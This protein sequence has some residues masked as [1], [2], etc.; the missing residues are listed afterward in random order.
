MRRRQLQA[1]CKS[2][3]QTFRCCR[4]RNT[5]IRTATRR[6]LMRSR[7]RGQCKRRGSAVNSTCIYDYYMPISLSQSINQLTRECEQSDRQYTHA[8]ISFG[9][10]VT[11]TFD[12]LNS[13]SMPT[14][15][16]PGTLSNKFGVDS[17]SRFLGTET[18]IHTKSKTPLITKSMGFMAHSFQ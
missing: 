13:G 5:I 3:L 9:D 10:R 6:N 7:T 18:D 16:L 1:R 11:L 14:E 2:L 15:R 4:Q 12:L 17:S 8:H